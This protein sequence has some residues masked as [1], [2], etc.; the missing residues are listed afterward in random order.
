MS[1][2][3]FPPVTAEMRR[4]ALEALPLANDTKA[5]RARLRGEI[6]AGKVKVAD[7]IGD[8]PA[9]MR[10]AKVSYALKSVEGI[11]DGFLNDICGRAGVM[12]SRQLRDLKVRER[13][14][15]IREL[16]RFAE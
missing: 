15:L 9:A 12:P 14:A 16:P 4:R 2:R 5:Q 3:T 6:R 11:G 8:P 13:L 1:V 10:T 7:V